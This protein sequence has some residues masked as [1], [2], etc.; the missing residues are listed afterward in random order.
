MI[1]VQIISV[2]AKTDPRLTCPTQC[3]SVRFVDGVGDAGG[4]CK[5]GSDV[6]ASAAADSALAS[7]A[8]ATVSP[9]GD[10]SGGAAATSATTTE[11]SAAA[12]SSDSAGSQLMSGQVVPES[13]AAAVFAIACAA[14]GWAV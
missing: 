4:N 10:A 13:M 6:K 14:L 7:L 9:T 12:T 3:A 5:N 8:T 11:E 2:Q 1:S